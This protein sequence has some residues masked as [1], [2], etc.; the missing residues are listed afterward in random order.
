MRYF[1]F[2]E[3]F[4]SS[5]YLLVTAVR[6]YPIAPITLK[7]R[8]KSSGNG[9]VYTGKT[10]EARM[11]EFDVEVSAKDSPSLREKISEIM[12]KVNYED[13]R[14]L[15][16]S[17]EPHIAYTATLESATMPDEIGATCE[18]TMRFY[19]PSAYREGG[20]RSLTLSSSYANHTAVG[21]VPMAWESLTVFNATT[22]RYTIEN[23][24]GDKITLNHAFGVGDRLE[25]DYSKRLIKLNGVARMALLSL[26][27]KWFVLQAG[28]NRLKASH[29]T[30]VNYK[31]IYF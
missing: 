3:R 31:E 22:T 27:S 4:N 17:D 9:E 2:D 25:I 13:V 8:R 15:V 12:S 5:E 16:V 26:D 1:T 7:R 29:G 28:T 20:R 11:I 10:L 23:D 21:H 14:K 24:K 30:T 6:R 19:S 18:F